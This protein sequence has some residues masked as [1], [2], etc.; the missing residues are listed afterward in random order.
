MSTRRFIGSIVLAGAVGAPAFADSDLVI[1]AIGPVTG[2]GAVG[3]IAGYSASVTHCNLGDAP[4]SWVA[5]AGTHPVTGLNLLRIRD[6]RL[7]MI[8]TSWMS[9]ALCPLQQDGCGTC[10]P[11]ALCEALGVGC[12]STSSAAIQGQQSLLGPRSEVNPAD[13]AFA[14]PIDAPDA[15]PTIGRRLQVAGADLDPALNPG[16]TYLL[17]AFTISA[18]DAGASAGNN[19]SARRVVVGPK[20]NGAWTL[21]T[22]GATMQQITALELWPQH[23]GGWGVAD[24][25]MTVVT[26]LVPGD[27]R[28]RIAA[29]ARPVAPE[30]WRYEYAVLDQDSARSV[31]SLAVPMPPGTPFWSAQSHLPPHHS[32]EPYDSTPWPAVGNGFGVEWSCPSFEANPNANALRFG[33]VGTFAFDSSA[34]PAPGVVTLGLFAPGMPAAVTAVLPVPSIAGDLNGDGRVNGD[35]LGTLLGAWD[36]AGFADLNADGVVNGDDLGTLLGHWTR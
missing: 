22:T 8:G 32:G 30:T 20:V 11:A 16:A 1:S 4:V 3:D 26:I 2:W 34:P 36:G 12:S 28:I 15:P 17:E 27:G 18:A 21:T 35:D 19:A 23:A 31:R 14:W 24:R 25:T 10:A 9:H 5:G 13:G 33:V 29:R 6:G 7:E